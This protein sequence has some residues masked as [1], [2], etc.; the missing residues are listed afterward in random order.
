[1]KNL[2]FNSCLMFDLMD[3]IYECFAFRVFL[4][5]VRSSV[6]NDPLLLTNYLLVHFLRKKLALCTQD[7]NNRKEIVNGEVS[8]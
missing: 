8:G 4:V 2:Y 5:C 3:V 1:M 7:T 6:Q